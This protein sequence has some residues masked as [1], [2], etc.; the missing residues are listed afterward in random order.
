M[1]AQVNKILLHSST[2][3]R[4]FE[5][6]LQM[7]FFSFLL[8]VVVSHRHLVNE[9]YDWH[10]RNKSTVN[11]KLVAFKCDP[12]KEINTLNSM[13]CN[14]FFLL[15]HHNS[16]CLIRAVFRSTFF[17]SIVVAH[18]QYERWPQNDDASC[19]VRCKSPSANISLQLLLLLPGCL[20]CVSFS[21]GCTQKCQP[22]F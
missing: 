2:R 13:G 1:L 18:A 16:F 9:I 8:V 12:E 7:F 10:P 5:I 15:H 4:R 17:P 20:L 11:H 19:R 22:Q 14:I 6:S 21:L 3:R